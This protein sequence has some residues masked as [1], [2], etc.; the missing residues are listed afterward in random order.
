[1]LGAIGLILPPL[2]GIAPVLSPIAAIALAALMLGAIVVHIR[3]KESFLPPLI[4]AV[5][6][7]VAAVLGFLTVV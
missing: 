3:R 7:I 2:L 6:S 4:L 1:M 5:L